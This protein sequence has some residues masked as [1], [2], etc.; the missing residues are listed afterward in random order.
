[1]TRRKFRKNGKPIII[2]LVVLVLIVLAFY[3]GTAETTGNVVVWDPVVVTPENLPA[4]LMTLQLIHDLPEKSNIYAK[5]GELEY[6]ITKGNVELGVPRNPDIIL[7]L[8][9]RYIAKLG[10]NPC[11]AIQEAIQ[12]RDLEIETSLSKASLFWKFKGLFKYKDCAGI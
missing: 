9:K 4:F 5:F 7:R 6:T 12:N 10:L 1:M 2:A 3:F 8:P 11:G